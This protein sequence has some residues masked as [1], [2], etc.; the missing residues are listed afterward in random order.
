MKKIIYV[1]DKCKKET[2]DFTKL[3]NKSDSWKEVTI[4]WGQYSE[5]K[6]LLCNECCEKLG[7]P[8]MKKANDLSDKQDTKNTAQKLYDIITE[9]VEENNA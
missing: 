9:I 1:C 7:I 2:M 8:V 5:E 6:M 3:W 4:K